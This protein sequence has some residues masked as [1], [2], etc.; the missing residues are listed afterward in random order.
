MPV[1]V[2]A[3]AALVAGAAGGA[4]WVGGMLR[5]DEVPVT[6]R[7]LCA[8]IEDYPTPGTAA[9]RP[10]VTPW[11]EVGPDS[12]PSTGVLQPGEVAVIGRAGAPSA[13]IRVGDPRICERYPTYRPR[14]PG[15]R[16]AVV[17]VEVKA[18]TDGGLAPWM[19]GDD[20][21]AVRAATDRAPSGVIESVV[22]IP[23]TWPESSLETPTGFEWA[24]DVVFRINDGPADDLFVDFHADGVQLDEPGLVSWA[25]GRRPEAEPPFD[26]GECWPRCGTS[27]SPGSL[28]GPDGPITTGRIGADEWAIVEIEGGPSGIRVG[29]GRPGGPLPGGDARARRVAW[30]HWWSTTGGTA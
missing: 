9:P 17:R 7:V 4:L 21:L 27:A 5:V 22:G 30:R 13:L 12:A 3:V 26:E 14:T 8:D 20:H 24:G 1:R 25:I 11:P 23:G 2:L 18:L 10:V 29:H 6:A 28:R 15:T 16:F 19:G